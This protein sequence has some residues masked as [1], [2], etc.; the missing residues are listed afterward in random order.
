M[1][2]AQKGPAILENPRRPRGE[3]DLQIAGDSVGGSIFNRSGGIHEFRLSQNL[4]TRQFGQASQSNQRGVPNVSINA[5]VCRNH[6][7]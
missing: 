7:I 5:R 4:A 3:N 6:V 2:P 1:G